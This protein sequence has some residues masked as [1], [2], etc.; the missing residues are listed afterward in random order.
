MIWTRPRTLRQ[1]LLLLVPAGLNICGALIGA[2]VGPSSGPL[3]GE[4]ALTW[5]AYTVPLGGLVCLALGFWLVRES[6]S[7]AWKIFGTL[8]FAI[9][10]AIVNVAIGF[11]GCL[12]V[13][14]AAGA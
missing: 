13:G 6:K 12:L 9:T 3:R 5:G 2:L 1:W 10:L 4:S 11:P 7:I 14:E 8:L